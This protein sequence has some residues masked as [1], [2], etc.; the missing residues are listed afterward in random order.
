MVNILKNKKRV[1]LE[2]LFLTLVIF[3]LGV[4]IGIL[5]ESNKLNQLNDYYIKTE[6]SI[7]DAFMLN[8][9]NNLNTQNC[10][11]LK[12][13][14]LDFADEIYQEA[15]ILEKYEN[16][17]K[18]TESMEIL[19]KKYDVLRTFLWFSTIKTSEKCG[20]KSS[21]VVYLYESQTEDLTKGQHR[22]SGQKFC[23]L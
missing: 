8:L 19:H 18:I 22:M 2:A 23:I 3:I 4:L 15:K 12:K 5:F 1:F 11:V 10:D 13:A 21:T 14:N 20:R 6:S 9:I 7:S 16:T 17:R